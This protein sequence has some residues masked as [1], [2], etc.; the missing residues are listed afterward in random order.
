[1]VGDYPRVI[2]SQFNVHI[3]LFNP[4]YTD[5][6]RYPDSVDNFFSR[7]SGIATFQIPAT[8]LLSMLDTRQ[9]TIIT[10]SYILEHSFEVKYHY[11][12]VGGP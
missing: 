9:F 10:M 2:R 8:V 4:F 12:D 5:K 3:H 6:M 1:M 7:S 11:S